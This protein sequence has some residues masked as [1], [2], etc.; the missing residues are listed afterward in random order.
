MGNLSCHKCQSTTCNCVKITP[1][2]YVE[3]VDCNFNPVYDFCEETISSDCV[4]IPEPCLDELNTKEFFTLTDFIQRVCSEINDLDN[5]IKCIEHRV[6]GCENVTLCTACSITTANENLITFVSGFNNL[7]RKLLVNELGSN[8][9]EEIILS[10]SS[11]SFQVEIS[12]DLN[13]DTVFYPNT[14]YEVKIESVCSADESHLSNKVQIFTVSED[15]WSFDVSNSTLTVLWNF[16][17]IQSIYSLSLTLLT[18]SDTVIK[19]VTL[20]ATQIGH[21]VFTDL[22]PD[23]NYKI[24]YGLNYTTNTT[25]GSPSNSYRKVKQLKTL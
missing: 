10:N 21:K 15:S 11:T 14:M 22:Q 2:G 18:E 1:V 3:D 7:S 4:I 6:G 9:V 16:Y 19:Q 5:R 23:T 24:R 13:S 8:V 17:S 25:F 20:P 12:G